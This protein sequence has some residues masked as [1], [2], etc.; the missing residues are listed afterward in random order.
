MTFYNM[1]TAWTELESPPITQASVLL[2]HNNDIFIIPT[3]PESLNDSMCKYSF[4][5]NKWIEII[6]KTSQS[7][8]NATIDEQ[9]Q[10]IYV[11]DSYG[12]FVEINLNTKTIQKI[13]TIRKMT[14]LIYAK[15][16]LHV[17]SDTK[18]FMFNKENNTFEDIATYSERKVGWS[19]AF[20]KS[21]SCILTTNKFRDKV[22]CIAEFSLID[23]KWTKYINSEIPYNS[24]IV[25]TK[26]DQYLICIGGRNVTLAEWTDSIFIYDIENNKLK[27][28]IIKC[29][30]KSFFTAVLTRDDNKD[31]LLTIGYINKCFKLSQ[32]SHIQPL[33]FYLL[34]IIVCYVCNEKINIISVEGESEQ[35]HWM[36][37]VDH[38]LQATK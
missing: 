27:T 31:E 23:H 5:K 30:S 19:F 15:N 12:Q 2:L 3:G 16:N 6:T 29:P 21:K 38:I 13:A 32:F 10:L 34:N 4:P 14:S 24:A 26:N 7:Y 18:Y 25:S 22:C 17:F 28:S 20:V 11:Y 9:N 36:I 8:Y 35:C 33:P 37:N 1:S